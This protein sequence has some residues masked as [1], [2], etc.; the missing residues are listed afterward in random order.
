MVNILEG[1]SKPEAY[2]E[3]VKEIKVIQTHISYVFL[4]GD[5]VYKVKKPV[6]FGFLDFT[7][8]EKR[9]YFCEKEVEINSKFSPDLYIGV[10]PITR[11]ENGEI[12]INGS[13]K[14]IDYVIKM[15][16]LPQERL[17]SKLLEK[18]EINEEIIDKIISILINFYSKTESIDESRSLGNLET[19]KFNWNENFETTKSFVNITIPEKI[20]EE[21]KNKVNNF[22]EINKELFEK[23]LKE[24]KIKWC[25]G[26]LHSNNI[27]VTDK[28]HIFD[29]IEFNERFAC[30]D[31][32]EDIA[33]LL[34]DLEFKNK[35]A[36]SSYFLEKFIE[37]TGDRDLLKLLDFYKCYRAY[38][39]GKVTSFKLN[40]P[41]IGREEKE[42]VLKEARSYFN[43]AFEYAKKL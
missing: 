9:K 11:E 15:K 17:M 29:G 13:G 27:F 3:E 12:K 38:V 21:I 2:D 34:M 31:I 20:F 19:I 4:T 1:L 7:T 16:E 41:N 18:D 35:K 36:L 24:N 23:R 28:I 42:R 6:N 26:D 22:F 14:V 33:F 43:L 30:I 8:L 25:H 10:L 39:R 5:Y 32:A 37:K 40:D